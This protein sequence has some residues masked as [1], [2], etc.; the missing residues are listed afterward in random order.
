MLYHNTGNMWDLANA[1]VIVCI[2]P[3]SKHLSQYIHIFQNLPLFSSRV[4]I[5]V[6][7]CD[8]L[9]YSRY[10]LIMDLSEGK[11]IDFDDTGNL[12]EKKIL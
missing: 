12:E 8:C 11:M 7:K 3:T 4:I 9:I 10:A 1:F 6:V 2:V 5:Y